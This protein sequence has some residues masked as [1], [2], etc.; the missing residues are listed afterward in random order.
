[1]WFIPTVSTNVLDSLIKKTFLCKIV[2]F[3]KCELE[4]AQGLKYIFTCYSGLSSNDYPLKYV[5]VFSSSCIEMYITEETAMGHLLLNQIIIVFVVNKVILFIFERYLWRIVW[6]IIC[7]ITIM[8]PPQKWGHKYKKDLI[9]CF[10]HFDVCVA[11]STISILKLI[12]NDLIFFI[13]QIDYNKNNKWG[14]SSYTKIC[15]SGLRRCPWGWWHHRW[16]RS[17]QSLSHLT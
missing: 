1:M 5:I 3:D 16:T 2:I 12:S 17:R 8:P 4:L 13:C 11:H 6:L 9:H 14:L 10:W 7:F 15:H